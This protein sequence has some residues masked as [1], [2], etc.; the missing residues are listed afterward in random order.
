[1]VV[2][3][4]PA[5]FCISSPQ[6][7]GKGMSSPP[8]EKRVEPVLFPNPGPLLT[9]QP[10]ASGPSTHVPVVKDVDTGDARLSPHTAWSHAV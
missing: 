9:T 6:S 2:L 8:E 3:E 1:M 5:P 10:R 7:R 4:V